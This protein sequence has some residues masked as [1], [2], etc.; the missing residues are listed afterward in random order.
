ML[1]ATPQ[2]PAEEI[3][4]E[5]LTLLMAAQEPPS[6]ALTWTLDRLARHPQLA[7]DYLAAGHGSPL[8]DAVL[9]ETLRMRP[10]ALASLRKLREPLSVGGHELP[11]GTATM[12]PLPLVHRDPRVFPDH[13]SFRPQRWLTLEQTPPTY[14]PFG[15]GVRRCIGEALAR[16]EVAAIVPA[17]LAAVQLTPLWPRAERMV[18]RGT[19]LVPHRSA[20]MIAR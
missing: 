11:A 7:A 8:R 18:L 6:I 1:A 12:V 20:P 3:V 4:G 19:V 14:L 13:D 10:S 2:P 9:S 17:V 5:V 15:G 16:A